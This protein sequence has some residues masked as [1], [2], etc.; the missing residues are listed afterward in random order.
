MD[1]NGVAAMTPVSPNRWVFS[2]PGCC[3]RYGVGPDAKGRS[4][5]L[6]RCPACRLVS[7]GVRWWLRVEAIEERRRALALTP[8]PRKDH[9]AI[10]AMLSCAAEHLRS[11]PNSGQHDFQA[12]L[13]ELAFGGDEPARGL[14]LLRSYAPDMNWSDPATAAAETETEFHEWE[15]DAH[16]QAAKSKDHMLIW[17]PACHTLNSHLIIG[18]LTDD[19]I[20][21]CPC[22]HRWAWNLEK[23]MEGIHRRIDALRSRLT[24]RV[25][26]QLRKLLEPP[27]PPLS[28]LT[29]QLAVRAMESGDMTALDHAMRV[30]GAECL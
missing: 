24:S 14:E 17:C 3:K 26:G 25:V 20:V 1:M 6:F 7:W 16:S 21:T 4:H 13:L 27:N 15:S 9:G 18:S 5:T 11:L 23:E 19:R 8:E 22:G 10:L 28:G 12:R 29:R 2:C 30:M